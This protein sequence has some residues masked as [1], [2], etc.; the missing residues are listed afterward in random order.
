MPTHTT[1]TSATTAIATM[2]C[3][4]AGTVAR[5]HASALV[6]IGQR[7]DLLGLGRGSAGGVGVVVVALPRSG[8]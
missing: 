7:V 3:I 4:G 6:S 8:S 2:P 1:P 5:Q